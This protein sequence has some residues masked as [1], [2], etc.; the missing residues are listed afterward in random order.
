[1]ARK[2]QAHNE[3]TGEGMSSSSCCSSYRNAQTRP[4]RR[5]RHWAVRFA[6]RPASDPPSDTTSA[7]RARVI[8]QDGEPA[9]STDG[10]LQ[11]LRSVTGDQEKALAA[12]VAD[13]EDAWSSHDM[14]RFAACF[15]EDADFINVRGWWWTGRDEIERRHTV[16]HETMFRKSS[17]H[18]EL[19]TT[20]EVC[21][22][23][24]IAHVR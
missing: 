8:R 15:A 3:R 20:R 22:R 10:T 11:L 9:G 5:R 16:L 23:V 2:T 19:V 21:P 6:F 1:G 14:Q 7:D 18:L 24:V 12:L 17:M 4:R 13:V